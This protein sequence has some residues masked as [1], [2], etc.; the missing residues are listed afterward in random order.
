MSIVAFGLIRYL[1]LSSIRDARD[2][3]T[4]CMTYGGW[5]LE[6]HCAASDA[7]SSTPR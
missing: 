1:S 2:V 5:A 3:S 6:V 4:M 7:A